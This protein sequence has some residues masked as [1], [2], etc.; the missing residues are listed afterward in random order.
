[1]I[2]ETSAMTTSA[3]EALRGHLSLTEVARLARVARP[4]VSMWR[5][6]LA[7]SDRPFPDPVGTDHGRDLFDAESVVTWL[8][9]TRL[10]NNPDARQD[11]IALGIVG[12]GAVADPD[13]FGALSALLCPYRVHGV[14][15]EDADDILDLADEYDPDDEQV[16]RELAGRGRDL[17]GLVRSANLLGG[18]AYD[19]A[20]SF[21]ALLARHHPD[22]GPSP[23]LV[24]LV[25]QLAD[26]LG[27]PG[28]SSGAFAIA[29]A[30]DTP[31]LIRLAELT[32]GRA[33]WTALLPPDDTAGLRQ[34]R[35]R[36]TAHGIGWRPLDGR[37]DELVVPDGAVLMTF[38]GVGEPRPL[39]ERA[40]AL[41]LALAPTACAILLGPAAALTDALPVPGRL[42]GRPAITDEPTVGPTTLV[43]RDVLRTRQ[44]RA[45]VRLPR[46]GLPGAPRARA[47][48]WCLGP[49]PRESVDHTFRAD[50][51]GPLDDAG[52][53]ALI[54]DLT[55]AMAGPASSREHIMTTG[56]FARATELQLTTGPLVPFTVPRPARVT[57]AET[58]D[59]V[60]DLLAR[61][62]EPLGGVDLVPPVATGT[63]GRPHTVPLAEAVAT[64]GLQWVAGTRIDRKLL[65]RATGIRVVFGPDDLRADP[66]TTIDPLVDAAHYPHSVRTFPG[67]LVV[68]S[69][70]RARARVDHDG[71][72]LVGWPARILRCAPADPD[73]PSFLP[74][75]V[76]A[77]LNRLP[78]GRASW[79]SWPVHVLSFGDLADA[80]R[81][82]S[83][84][85]RA[86]REAEDRMVVLDELTAALTGALS[87]RTL[88]LTEPE[89]R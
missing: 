46:G 56:G 5:T 62:S 3:P 15:P 11:A 16:Y 32:E 84:L 23:S 24:A 58:A 70:P 13:A 68:T 78:A 33:D 7:A 88:R 25:A 26:A 10:G 50:L 72:T 57:A 77:D 55:A 67:D 65:T 47:A 63:S 54:T 37:G 44:L 2:C 87:S 85:D 51:D 28:R 12:D 29:G 69:S 59:Q 86:R 20:D 83:M 31:F 48:L 73:R 30:E 17:P 8:E 71:G 39:L 14:L 6:R 64:G 19:V 18:A 34:A 21:E 22:A 9:R 75:A 81:A 4:V 35:R 45:A 40:S 53:S 61:A 80:G 42:R 60:A 43:R 74:E 49:Q 66:P 79:Q 38:L 41:S 36:L 52:T 82:L 27:S 76:A 1:M 89:G